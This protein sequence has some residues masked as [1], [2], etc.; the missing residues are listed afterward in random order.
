[1]PSIFDDQQGQYITPT[2]CPLFEDGMV[3]AAVNAQTNAL[4]MR[5]QSQRVQ[6]M[7]EGTRVDRG[8]P[9]AVKG[10]ELREQQLAQSQG[11]EERET[12]ERIEQGVERWRA[13][14]VPVIPVTNNTVSVQPPPSYFRVLVWNLENFTRD[15]R[16]RGSA[17]ID[18]LRNQARIAI[19]A[20]AMEA[21][22]ADLL[23]MMETGRDVGPATTHIGQYMTDKAVAKGDDRAWHPLVSPVTG[24]MPKVGNVYPSIKPGL[25][26]GAKVQAM[27]L[28]FEVFRVRPDYEAAPAKVTGEQIVQAI[29][30]LRSASP[31]AADALPSLQQPEDAAVFDDAGR[32][33]PHPDLLRGWAVAAAEDLRFI[34]SSLPF[35]EEAIRLLLD[36]SLTVAEGTF[37]YGGLGIAH[38]IDAA[39]EIIGVLR[40]GT[41]DDDQGELHRT[42]AIGRLQ[43]LELL[44]LFALK[45]VSGAIPQPEREENAS[46]VAAVFL[47]E[48]ALE[49][50]LPLAA[51]FCTG[52]QSM[53]ARAFDF[54][55]GPLNSG[56]DPDLVLEA[57]Q[58]LNMTKRNVETYG[59][60]Y[61]APYP[62]A[63]ALLM[64]LGVLS[65]GFELS[66]D[67]EA[68][69][70]TIV[71]EQLNRQ[72]FPVQ[73]RGNAL[74]WRSGLQ[75]T[76]PVAPGVNLPFVVYHTRYSGT[77]EIKKLYPDYITNDEKTVVA[78]CM[79]VVS[80]A[81]AV[82]PGGTEVGPPLIVG[83]FNI[84][85]PYL[86]EEAEPT[87]KN[88]IVP[89]TR[90]K[91][92]RET[93]R[94]GMIGHG[95][96]RHSQ[97]GQIGGGYPLTTLKSYT[98]I[99]A[100]ADPGSQPY[101][102]V[103]QPFDYAAG[104]VTLRSGV[105]GI[106][107][108]VND[109][110]LAHPI[111]GVASVG[112]DGIAVDPDA[113]E[114]DEEANADG[115]EESDVPSAPQEMLV[116]G[117]MAIEVGRVYRG[118]LSKIYRTVDKVTDWSRKRI[119]A[120]DDVRASRNRA[121]S[122]EDLI[123]LL[124][125]LIESQTTFALDVIEPRVAWFVRAMA[126]GRTDAYQPGGTDPL[127]VRLD[128]YANI[129]IAAKAYRIRT[130]DALPDDVALV[131]TQLEKLETDITTRILIG[132]RA[133]VSDHLPTIIEFAVRQ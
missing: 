51:F 88:S 64:D 66:M 109:H 73:T 105:V 72:S 21:F 19:V 111:R 76:I 77:A 81:E 78:R 130:F 38:A 89:W 8:N 33:F 86:I 7:E 132:Y 29:D 84:P 80:M 44:H 68:A 125:A 50:P 4:A 95:F 116:I 28:L 62:E 25:P 97:D 108:L 61:R 42:L 102:G 74:N 24:E 47:S 71:Q 57:M 49:S 34:G 5:H 13:S 63:M 18:S 17:P 45:S 35:L 82:L 103:Y 52:V 100:G 46:L 115:E 58:R 87:R 83:D 124:N 37:A 6:M 79:S 131:R 126:E 55:R 75:I 22:D 117:A 32:G 90:R 48:Q 23:L 104:K 106:N 129:K 110:V 14:L 128:L 114:L 2:I 107:G 39:R 9:F 122:S 11:V 54:K 60:L 96:L 27:S 99:A 127:Q 133:V 36:L 40:D 12:R 123:P 94:D 3:Q 119:A 30:V 98:S 112:Q 91:Q 65:H 20:A 16:P 31:D 101:D 121:K 41:F 59:M 53:K 118:F 69:R 85:A 10:H 15:R 120:G 70:Y 56:V 67:E 93:F 26:T 43:G 92:A 1:M 113:D